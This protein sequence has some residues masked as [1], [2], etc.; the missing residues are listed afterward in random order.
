MHT[1]L[2]G[3]LLVLL[4]I[5]LGGCMRHPLSPTQIVGD[6]QATVAVREFLNASAILAYGYGLEFNYVDAAP[7]RQLTQA[8]SYSGFFG[9]KLREDIAFDISVRPRRDFTLFFADARTPEERWK[10][11]TRY[12]LRSGANASMII[13]RNYLAG[14]KERNEY[15]EFLQKELNLAGGL[16][17]LTLSLAS[18]NRTITTSFVNAL[19]YLNLGLDAY[20][21]FRY[22]SVD[23]ETVITM[24]EAAQVA[25]RDHFLEDNNLPLSFA[26]ALHALNK[27]EYVC[28]RAGI[29][30]L[31]NKTLTQVPPAYTVRAN[32]ILVTGTKEQNR[33]P[34]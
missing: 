12:Y 17:G 19:S 31:L 25:L 23:I 30:G 21:D 6:R 7:S 32:G 18:A 15:F 33:P 5:S 3:I 22:L 16:A 11:S 8:N 9:L 10:Q 28:T 4:S 13:C 29:R 2:A 27:I 26:A 34:Q 20:Q 1:K 24:V 14:L